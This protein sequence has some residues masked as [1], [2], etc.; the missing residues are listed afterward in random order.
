MTFSNQVKNKQWFGMQSCFRELVKSWTIQSEAI[1]ALHRYL[2]LGQ[3]WLVTD[4][5]NDWLTGP[6]LIHT[7]ILKANLSSTQV[8][9]Q[10]WN[11]GI[12]N[13]IY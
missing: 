2:D 13:T 3:D 7:L 5:D 6:R 9:T 12:G 8:S 11:K 4:R 1:A 10:V